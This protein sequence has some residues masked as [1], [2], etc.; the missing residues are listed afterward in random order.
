M[1]P[2]TR[3]EY[4]NREIADVGFGELAGADLILTCVDSDLART[5]AA[6]IALRMNIPMADAGLGGAD[7]WRGRVSFFAG[8]S[9]ACFCCK[10]SPR[11]RRELLALSIS[12]G[13]SCWATDEIATPR[14]STPTMAAII[15]ALQVDFGLHCLSEF[16]NAD[17]RSFQSPTMEVTLGSNAG[18][19]RFVTSISPGCPFHSASTQPSVLLPRV[20]A[21]A[22]EL[23]DA[24][25]AQAID[26]DWP[27][28]VAA[29]CLDCASDWKPMKRVA[30]LR[31]H[32]T[33]PGCGGHRV[34]EGQNVSSL[35]RNSAWVDMPLADLG[36]P[37]H[38]LYALRPVAEEEGL[39]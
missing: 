1:F 21:T 2:G 33:C 26:L 28:C 25:G 7:D 8:R 14:P 12:A 20:R 4:H 18:M 13:H 15:G 32:G 23:L 39:E 22:R 17:A 34:L 9:S 35:D 24:A 30:W 38:H 37:E 36:L 29:R 10:L 19:R 31:R 3:W 11:R 6:W 5:E 27:I 16:E